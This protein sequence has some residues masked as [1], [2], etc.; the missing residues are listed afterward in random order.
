M[1]EQETPTRGGFFFS[2]KSQ[3]FVHYYILESLI[4][5]NDTLGWGFILIYETI[6][7]DFRGFFMGGGGQKSSLSLY[8]LLHISM[9]VLEVIFIPAG[10][11]SFFYIS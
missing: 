10:I 1:C 4:R 6:Y 2:G 11:G 9:R 3:S 8:I 5:D 7:L